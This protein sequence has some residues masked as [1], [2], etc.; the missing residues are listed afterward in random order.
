M[1]TPSPLNLARPKARFSVAA[2][3]VG[4]PN[5][6]HLFFTTQPTDAAPLV[7]ISI[8]V[9]D[10]TWTTGVYTKPLTGALEL[11]TSDNCSYRLDLSTLAPEASSFRLEVTRSV[12]QGNEYYLRGTLDAELPSLNRRASMVVK[13]SIN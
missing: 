1:T 8:V 6:S 7:Y 11:T 2:A 9:D 3:A 5:G 4:V 10:P 12:R 13:M